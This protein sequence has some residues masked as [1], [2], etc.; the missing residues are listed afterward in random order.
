MQF[1]SLA[2]TVLVF[3]K[4]RVPLTHHIQL[5]RRL[6]QE[7]LENV[8]EDGNCRCTLLKTRRKHAMCVGRCSPLKLP[9][10]WSWRCWPKIQRWPFGFSI[11]Q[12]SLCGKISVAP[13]RSK[14]TVPNNDSPG[15][16]PCFLVFKYCRCFMHQIQ[17][18]PWAPKPCRV[19]ICS[20]SGNDNVCFF[21]FVCL[22]LCLRVSVILCFCVCAVM[23]TCLCLCV[24]VCLFVC[25]FVCAKIHALYPHHCA[26]QG[27]VKHTHC[28]AQVTDKKADWVYIGLPRI[29]H[30]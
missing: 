28:L 29:A 4:I 7:A 11:S 26:L 10:S 21:V 15:N 24:F 2:F 8:F 18:P 9:H 16:W 5:G 6:H 12:T 13:K 19:V 1:G 20:L 17:I 27:T 3:R 14:K 22:C 23:Y 30:C 25:L